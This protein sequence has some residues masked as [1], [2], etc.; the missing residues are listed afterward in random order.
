LTDKPGE[1]ILLG[2]LD[3]KRPGSHS[4]QRS[5]EFMAFDSRVY[6]IVIG[7]PSD[8]EEER[9]IAVRVIQE[10]NDLHSYTR[11]VVLLPLRWETHT[12]PDY[13]TRPQEVI[14]E[15]SLIDVICWLVSS[16]R[17]SDHQPETPRVAPLRRSI[18][19]GVQANQ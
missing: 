11:K 1:T 8:V 7:S 16:G 13:G 12:A 2:V 19:W 4:I 14:N 18:E 15:Q 10:W 6:R 9:D 3:V 17:E 5:E